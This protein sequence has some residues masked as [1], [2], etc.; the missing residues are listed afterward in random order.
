MAERAPLEPLLVVLCIEF[1]SDIRLKKIVT[2][3]ALID[4]FKGVLFSNAHQSF[5]LSSSHSSFLSHLREGWAFPL[6]SGMETT[7][8]PLSFLGVLYLLE[9]RMD[10][11]RLLQEVPK[12]GKWVSMPRRLLRLLLL[13]RYHE[14]FVPFGLVCEVHGTFTSNYLRGFYKP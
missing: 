6:L 2:F 3:R 10:R 5:L 14:G 11:I 9:Q 8:P 13:F 4:E 1:S 7:H 12:A